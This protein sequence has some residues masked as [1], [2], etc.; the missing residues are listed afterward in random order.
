[1]QLHDCVDHFGQFSHSTSEHFL[2]SNQ[3]DFC[4]FNRS[5][6]DTVNQG[7]W[8]LSIKLIFECFVIVA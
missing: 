7:N 5:T 4:A 2:L 1:M 3:V 6:I 8:C